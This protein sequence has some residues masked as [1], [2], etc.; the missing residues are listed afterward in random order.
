MYIWMDYDQWYS[1]QH[2]SYN[3]QISTNPYSLVR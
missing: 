2:I 3:N 1:P